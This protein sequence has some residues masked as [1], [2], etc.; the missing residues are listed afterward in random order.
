MKTAIV[1]HDLGTTGDKACVFTTEGELKATLYAPFTTYYPQP[2]H[3][4][5]RPE[6]WWNTLCHTTQDILRAAQTSPS[7]VACLVFSGHN[8][9]CIPVDDRGN[10][11]YQSIPIYAD[12]RAS[13]QVNNF[14]KN[15]GGHQRF[16]QITGGGNLPEQYALFKMLWFKQHDPD[17]FTRTYKFI[18]TH[19]Y[20]VYKLTGRFVTDY[21]LASNIGLLDITQLDWSEELLHAAEIPREMLPELVSSTEVVGTVAE[22]VSSMLGLLPGTPVVIGGGDVCCATTGAGVVTEGISYANVG[23]NAWI[24]IYSETPQFNF[25]T[26]LV[27]FCHLKTGSYALHFLTGG[28]SICYKWLRD[29]LFAPE[30]TWAGH[31][32]IDPYEL[33]NLSAQTIPLGADRLIFLPYMTGVWAGNFQ[34][35]AR[36]AF[37]GL[38]PAHTKAHIV[39]AVIEGIGF[40]LRELLEMFHQ[41]DMTPEEIR[42][43]GGGARNRPYGGRSLRISAA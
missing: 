35:N 8:P 25:D 21:S 39:R 22:Q 26:H 43:I 41:Q 6:D 15:I 16:Y 29:A 28:G 40:G 27:N 31:L 2:N 9:S 42:I 33:M 24:G 14:F 23:A 18:N 3:V 10:L 1:V 7:D 20:L 12:L 5:Q 4:E 19:D 37:I 36:G 13:Q 17:N 11:I 32:D 30:K 34:P 38:N